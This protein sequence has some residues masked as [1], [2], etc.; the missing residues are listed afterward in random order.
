M[1]RAS[2]QI[3]SESSLKRLNG[4][5]LIPNHVHFDIAGT[6]ELEFDEFAELYNYLQ[7][8]PKGGKR[9]FGFGFGFGVKGA[10]EKRQAR[11]KKAQKAGLIKPQDLWKAAQNNDIAAVDAAIA[12]GVNVEAG[13]PD[14]V[15][16]RT[17][18]SLCRLLCT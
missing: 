7:K 17:T 5:A 6:G 10:E 9:G 16:A 14:D 12:A 4:L 11:V 15:R 1:R 8:Q 2:L 13:D 18:P 3:V